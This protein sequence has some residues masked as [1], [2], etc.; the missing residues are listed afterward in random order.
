MQQLHHRRLDIHAFWPDRRLRPDSAG[1][2]PDRDPG[3]QLFQPFDMPAHFACPDGKPKAIRGRDTLLP[4]CPADCDK[5]CCFAGS[6]YQH[7]EESA[8]FCIGK[9]QRLGQ[10]EACRRIENVI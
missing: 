2:L 5:R 6:S 8:Q 4:V 3:A 10:L 9:I 1:H 7:P